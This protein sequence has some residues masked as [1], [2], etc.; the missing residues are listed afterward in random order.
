M[1]NPEIF[2]NR[3]NLDADKRK[4]EKQLEEFEELIN[5]NLKSLV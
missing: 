4:L 5:Q 3:K 2:A 1:F